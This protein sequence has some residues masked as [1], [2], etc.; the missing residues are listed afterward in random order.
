[1]GDDAQLLGR[2]QDVLRCEPDVVVAYLFGSHARGEAGPL[3]DVDI[4][5]LLAGDGAAHGRLLDTLVERLGTERIDLVSLARAPL[6]LRYRAVRDGRL[7][8]CR[9]EKLRQRF[10]AESVLRYL[11]FKPLRDRALALVRDAVLGAG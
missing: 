8:V 6:P 4:G 1:M 3:S 10:E 7:L 9:D 11:D 2:I 5:V